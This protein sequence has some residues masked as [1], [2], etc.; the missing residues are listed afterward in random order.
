M[1]IM[2]KHY[3]GKVALI[4][5]GASG[6][7]AALGHA[8]ANLG[9]E[10]ILADIQV[11]LAEDTAHA[12]RKSG[13]NAKS[14]LL[15][16]TDFYAF[17]LVLNAVYEEF[18]K[19]DFLFNNAGIIVF[20]KA[21]DHSIEDWQKV[22]NVNLCGVVNGVQCGYRIMKEQGFG[23]IINTAS[24]AGLVPFPWQ[25]SYAST[26]T[27]IVTLSEILR[28]E[29]AEFGVSISVLCPGAVN[30]PILDNG[31]VY[32]KFDNSFPVEE[33]RAVQERL[34]ISAEQFATKALLQIKRNKGVI[35]VP[36]SW[37]ILWWFERLFPSL[38]ARI[39]H[40]FLNKPTE[41]EAELTR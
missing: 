15:D 26:K 23:H 34:S 30:T 27:A 14:L 21:Q 9:C 19:I 18:G 35:I 41:L 32:G 10:V 8:L 22:I 7:G 6:I 17:N 20:A 38:V 40:K 33:Q 1:D 4:T 39:G 12:I 24:L 36:S 31:G 11:D 2:S 37:K 28:A 3:S 13:G 29:A 5:G 16:A 25:I